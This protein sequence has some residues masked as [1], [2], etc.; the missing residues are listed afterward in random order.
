MLHNA[1]CKQDCDASS[2][3]QWQESNNAVAWEELYGWPPDP[4]WTESNWPSGQP[5]LELFQVMLVS[6][7][8]KQSAFSIQQACH[9]LVSVW[10]SVKVPSRSARYLGLACFKAVG[11]GKCEITQEMCLVPLGE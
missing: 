8:R 6:A 1:V 7:C 3:F 10:C 4:M 5:A 11:A 9:V 2:S